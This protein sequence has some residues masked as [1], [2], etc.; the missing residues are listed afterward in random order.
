MNKETWQQVFKKKKKNVWWVEGIKMTTAE[1][2]TEG[3]WE[4][5]PLDLLQHVWA[6]LSVEDHEWRRANPL[7]YIFKKLIN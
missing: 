2:L 7:I 5:L 4:S 3:E 1:L 6:A